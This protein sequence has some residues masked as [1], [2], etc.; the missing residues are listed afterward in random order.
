KVFPKAVCPV[1]QMEDAGYRENW[2]TY[3]TGWYAAKELT[4]LPGRS[5]TIKD[6]A[7]YGLIVTQGHGTFGKHAVSAPTMIRFGQMTEDELFVTADKARQAVRIQNASAS[8]PPPRCTQHDPQRAAPPGY[9]ETCRS[10]QSRRRATAKEE[11]AGMGATY[12]FPK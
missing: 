2:V 8:D 7:A 9:L 3:G 4:V 12:N 10:R 5:V 1:K 6:G 11:V